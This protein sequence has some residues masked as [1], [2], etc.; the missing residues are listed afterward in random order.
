MV[1]N[2]ANATIYRD[3]SFYNHKNMSSVTRLM[4]DYLRAGVGVGFDFGWAGATGEFIFINNSVTITI[5]QSL[6]KIKSNRRSLISGVWAGDRIYNF[7][8]VDN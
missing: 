1:L 6:I 2:V 5:S 7:M 3:P 4:F 8:A